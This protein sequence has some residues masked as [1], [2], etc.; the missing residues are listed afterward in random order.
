MNQEDITARILMPELVRKAWDNS[1]ELGLKDDFLSACENYR[2]DLDKL[3]FKEGYKIQS[4]YY[5]FREFL[6][7]HKELFQQDLQILEE[8]TNEQIDYALERVRE[9]RR[10]YISSEAEKFVNR[11]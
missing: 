6:T 5:E 7:K 1:A 8:L 4:F 3:V 2:E 11:L 9:E 10:K